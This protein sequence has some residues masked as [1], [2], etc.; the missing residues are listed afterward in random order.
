MNSDDPTDIGGDSDV[1][2]I[3][4]PMTNKKKKKNGL[5]LHDGGGGGGGNESDA[6]T[7][8]LNHLGIALGSKSVKTL[9]LDEINDAFTT[10]FVE[11]VL[12]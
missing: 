11:S 3:T 12:K 7:S 4:Q 8:A 1:P 9:R 6:R 10:Q 5:T 2:G